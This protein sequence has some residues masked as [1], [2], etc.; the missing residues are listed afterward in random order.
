MDPSVGSVAAA[1]EGSG[2]NYSE[3]F[4]RNAGLIS[5][6][7]QERLRSSRVAIAGMG[8]VG[9]VHLA[10]LA[11]L[12]VGR[13]TI[14]DPDTFETANTNRQ[15]GAR[16]DTLG[17]PKAEVMAEEVL[18]INPQAEV[19]IFDGAISREGVGDF[20][21]DADVFVDGM[22]LFEMDIRRALFDAAREQGIHSLTAGPMGFGC[23]WMVFSPDGVTVDEY[24]GL[25]D[26]MGDLDKVVAFV[27]GLAPSAFH[28]T[29]L[30]MTAVNLER[31][32]GP[33]LGSACGL[34][35]GVIGAEVCRVLLGRGGLRCAPFHLEFDPFRYRFK[36]GK[37]GW[38][39]RHTVQRLR[40]WV[41]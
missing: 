20:L 37:T 2:W 15:Y 27:V 25:S 36:C 6:A 4:C 23:A 10:T 28:R 31:R 38:V 13:F 3:A 24:F 19:T 29:Y 11:R 18:K 22:D 17:R 30:D 7:E 34:A 21:R 1:G 40:C 12:G 32:H 16:T 26:R 5:E 41:L 8:G 9:G 39:R 14:A 35:A 33:S